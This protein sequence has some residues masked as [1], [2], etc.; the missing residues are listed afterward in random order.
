MDIPKVPFNSQ[1]PIT[2]AVPPDVS[3]KKPLIISAVLIIIAGIISGFFLAKTGGVNKTGVPGASSA[4]TIKTDT[5]AGTLDTTTFKDQARGKLEQGGLNGEGTHH[6][7]RTGGASQTA[8]LVSSLVDLDQFVGKQVEIFGQ[9][10][11]A[12]SVGWLM[13]VGRVKVIQ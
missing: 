8:Y 9:T 10:I 4:K 1:A 3:S 12:K 5:E 2:P 11:K 13:D 7:T 6:L